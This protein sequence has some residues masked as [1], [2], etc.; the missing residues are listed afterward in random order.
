MALA[1]DLDITEGPYRL[2]VKGLRDTLRRLESAGADAESMRD[3]MHDL[4]NIVVRDA[5]RRAPKESGA[6]A[7]TLRAGR[8]K[9]K[10][11]VRAGSAR[12][13]Y[14]GVVHYGTPA[15]HELGDRQ[16]RPFLLDALTATQQQVLAGL[17]DGISDILRKNNLT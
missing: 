11:V 7:T 5:Q 13:P 17:I 4:G 14:A 2:K 1:G 10:A 15:G 16:P 8:G 6:L 3:L 12:V 9:T